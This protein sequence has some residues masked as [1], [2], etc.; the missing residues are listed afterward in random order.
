MNIL[1]SLSAHLQVC[2]YLLQPGGDALCGA[3]VCAA[4]TGGL[5]LQLCQS[6][7]QYSEG[8]GLTSLLQLPLL[9]WRRLRDPEGN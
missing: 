5:G 8:E 9:T 2:Q 1:H 4:Y 3:R 6:W 7:L